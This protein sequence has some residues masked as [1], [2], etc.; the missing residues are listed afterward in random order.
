MKIRTFRWILLTAGAL[1]LFY[2]LNVEDKLLP[3][4]FNTGQPA[5]YDISGFAGF[6]QLSVF[7]F[8]LIC[9]VILKPYIYNT[10]SKK[11]YQLFVPYL[12]ALL[13]LP[14][15]F[16]PSRTEITSDTITTH[17]LL[18]QVSRVYSIEDAQSVNAKLSVNAF[19]RKGSGAQLD[20][21]LEYRLTFNDG[22][23]YSLSPIS[24]DDVCWQ[25]LGDINDTVRENGIEKEVS[26]KAHYDLVSEYYGKFAGHT[27]LLYEILNN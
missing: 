10:M 9:W 24:E 19:F 13:I 1:H 15:L 25:V 2:I 12:T 22:F 17:N 7:P 20:V 27:D 18:G 3:F 26:G 5:V 6:F 21:D 16:Y 14:L 23:E 11:A 4:I 8:I